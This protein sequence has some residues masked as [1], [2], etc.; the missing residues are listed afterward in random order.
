MRPHLDVGSLPRM[1]Q[2]PGQVFVV[3][4]VDKC[5]V[6]A[7]FNRASEQLSDQ[8]YYPELAPVPFLAT[9]A[10]LHIKIAMIA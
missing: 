9:S 2:I 6:L 3:T 5:F 7:V 1:R 10:I 4:R 8:A